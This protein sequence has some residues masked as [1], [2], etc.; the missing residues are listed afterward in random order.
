M[1]TDMRTAQAKHIAASC[2]IASSSDGGN[3]LSGREASERVHQR[4][5]EK[6]QCAAATAFILH[7]QQGFELQAS[8]VPKPKCFN[9]A[10][11]HVLAS[12]LKLAHSLRVHQSAKMAGRSAETRGNVDLQ[13]KLHARLAN[14]YADPPA[15]RV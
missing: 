15:E 6:E 12:W 8:F 14:T 7:V 13:N 11:A 1:T 4:K 10:T 9:H 3:E 2:G 5:H